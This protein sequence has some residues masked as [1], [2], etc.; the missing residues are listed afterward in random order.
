MTTPSA[1]L[2]LFSP[3]PPPPP[4]SDGPLT[5]AELIALSLL[6]WEKHSERVSPAGL[7]L[8]RMRDDRSDDR[9]YTEERTPGGWRM[10][11]EAGV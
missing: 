10:A 8:V 3:D 2:P 1:Q 7:L 9:R 6:G 11:L 4:P 5:D